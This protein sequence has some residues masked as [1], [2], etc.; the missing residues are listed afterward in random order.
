ML[1]RLGR[2]SGIGT[3][4]H[5]AGWLISC[6]E[7]KEERTPVEGLRNSGRRRVCGVA[8]HAYCILP[9][10]KLMTGWHL[11]TCSAHYCFSSLR[12]RAKSALCQ[13]RQT[14]H[15]DVV[16]ELEEMLAH[17]VS[18]RARF[19]EVMPSRHAKPCRMLFLWGIGGR[20]LGT[21]T[22]LLARVGICAFRFDGYDW[23]VMKAVSPQT[24]P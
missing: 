20:V 10:S 22:A 12:P 7:S 19:A 21:G 11:A 16:P 13:F 2:S 8:R 3:K 5:W 24:P 15:S 17:E 18:H 14:E 1:V 9:A 4:H 6:P 23:D